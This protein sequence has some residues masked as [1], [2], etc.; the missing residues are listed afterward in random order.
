MRQ[1]FSV[2]TT[3]KPAAR[4]SKFLQDNE[5]IG[6]CVF[7]HWPVVILNSEDEVPLEIMLNPNVNQVSPVSS[8]NRP[9][10]SDFVAASDSDWLVISNSDVWIIADWHPI[11]E[12]L[13]RYDINFASS[14][15]WDLPEDL[16]V[17]EFSHLEELPAAELIEIA[18]RQSMRTLDAFVVRRKAL[19]VAI[20]AKREIGELIPG[21]VGFDNNLFGLMLEFGRAA[22]IT[23][24]VEIFHTN[25]EPFRKVYRRNH[26][27][28]LEKQNRFIADRDENREL[29]TAKGCLT[30]ADYRI[31]KSN[32]GFFR[33]KNRFRQARC[34]LESI[35]V[36][37][38]NQTDKLIFSLNRRWFDLLR[39]R[40]SRS[41]RVRIFGVSVVYPSL[42]RRSDKNE[43][44]QFDDLV[45]K[46]V[47]RK[48]QVWKQK[49][50]S[51]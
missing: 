39:S 42:Q 45:T 34:Y 29:V 19:E 16:R 5:L 22:D 43:P 9:I 37:L 38:V 18:K 44:G 21:T 46:E 10:L 41:V 47:H 28:S 23:S 1:L 14:M 24:V 51:G 36:K 48:V 27:V 50:G 33:R 12:F 32:D 7:S 11:I 40:T 8:K 49:F 2:L 35:R 30:W 20:A 17:S 6:C 31:L 3:C 15:R 4:A 13:E 26:L 25:H